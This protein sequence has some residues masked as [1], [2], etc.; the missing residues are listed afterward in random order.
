VERGKVEG[1]RDRGGKGKRKEEREH[2][3][4]EMEVK[5][6]EMG[7]RKWKMGKGKEER[8]KMRENRVK[9]ERG[10]EKGE[11]KRGNGVGRKGIEVRLL[12]LKFQHVICNSDAWFANHSPVKNQPIRRALHSPIQP[13]TFSLVDK[14]RI[15]SVSE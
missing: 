2:W 15:L 3:N 12:V 9:K 5:T 6:G 7:E 13:M 8:G 1:E 14:E 11:E 10:R 4:R